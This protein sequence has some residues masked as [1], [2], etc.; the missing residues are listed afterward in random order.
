MQLWQ[1]PVLHYY[2]YGNYS[3]DL[4]LFSL[5]SADRNTLHTVISSSRIVSWESETRSSTVS[6]PSASCSTPSRA[7]G[8]AGPRYAALACVGFLFSHQ[9]FPSLEWVI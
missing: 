7:V 8:R 2:T 6:T 1:V 9:Q 4:Y 3:G 5:L